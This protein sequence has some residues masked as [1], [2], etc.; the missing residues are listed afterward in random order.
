MKHGSLDF[1][2]RQ[3]LFALGYALMSTWATILLM[4]SFFS[5]ANTSTIVTMSMLPGLMACLGA[6]TLRNAVPPFDGRTPAASVYATGMAVGT[7]LCTYPSLAANPIVHNAGLL[8]CGFFAILL[9]LTWFDVFSRFSARAIVC[10]AGCALLLSAAFCYAIL[11]CP[12]EV[13]SIA[14]AALPLVSFSLMPRYAYP[15]PARAKNP[16]LAATLREAVSWKTLLGIVISFFVIGAIGAIIPLE[17]AV[18]QLRVPYLAI[19]ACLAAIFVATALL[20][21][22]RI[23]AS[24]FFKVLQIAMACLAFLLVYYDVT[25]MS[26]VFFAYIT[27]DVLLWTVMLL[28]AKKTPV[29]PYAVFAIGWLAECIGNV[30]GHNVAAAMGDTTTLFA[31]VMILTLVGVGFAFGDGLFVL[32]LE[33]AG[34]TVGEATRSNAAPAGN[35][36]KGQ[37]DSDAHGSVE[38]PLPPEAN[39]DETDR[40]VPA[41]AGQGDA[42]VQPISPES[43]IAA[44]STAHGLSAREIDVFAL[45]VTGHGL[46]YIQDTL[47]I[48]EATVKTH[49]RHIYGKCG[50]HSRADIIALFEEETR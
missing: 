33:E 28:A 46:K 37:A 48:G 30:L 19:P 1:R 36:A 5:T 34:S 13:A 27:A 22:P 6:L 43:A 39:L 23:D 26:P 16:A 50:T 10:M 45:W 44:F 29:E 12:V 32:D 40:A 24:I 21:P 2:P 20:A 49:L 35:V 47:F 4:S 38:A 25:S 18:E 8:V 9:I 41:V 3:V 31:L 15:K 17:G 7:L 14:M 11:S 42:T